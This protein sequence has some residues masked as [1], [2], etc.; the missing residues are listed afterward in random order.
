MRAR[1]P[2]PGRSAK[3]PGAH[4]EPGTSGAAAVYKPHRHV[5]R[6]L[7]M[8]RWLRALLP[9]AIVALGLPLAVLV[10]PAVA[11]AGDPC[12]HGF[13]MPARSV[14]TASAIKALPCAFT[15]TIAY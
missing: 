6:R 14:A 9:P 12:F 7:P 11:L 13:D 5:R 8:N 2:G 1:S 10:A 4:D 15:P 3:S